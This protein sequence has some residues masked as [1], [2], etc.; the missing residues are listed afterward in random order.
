MM[1]LLP[2][3][4]LPMSLLNSEPPVRFIVLTAK[5]CRRRKDQPVT[6][7][8]RPLWQEGRGFYTPTLLPSVLLS[9]RESLF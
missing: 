1:S 4:L 5:Q 2:M 8:G 9:F 7:L 3:S 6:K